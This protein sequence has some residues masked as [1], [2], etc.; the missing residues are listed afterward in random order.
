MSKANFTADR[1]IN[2]KCDDGKQQSIYWDAKTPGLGLRV[3][4]NGAK[5]YVFESRLHGKSLR[6]TIG[7]AK[8]WT[9]GKAQ[10][11]ASRLR[12]LIDQGIDPRQEKAAKQ[13]AAELARVEAKRQSVTLGEVWGVYVEERRAKWSQLSYRDHIDLSS[14]GGEA[15]KRG[16]GMTEPGPLASLLPRKMCSLTA[17]TIHEWMR[18]EAY[19][20]PTRTRLAFNLLRIFR[21]WCESKAEY[22]GLVGEG[23]LDPRMTRD[24]LPKRRP[25]TDVIQREQLPAWFTAVFKIGNPVMSAYLVGLLMTGAR[26]RS[27]PD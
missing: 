7:N 22:C 17:D 1:V 10:S 8:S 21:A 25:K 2:F 11:E 19:K 24:L 27:W 13:N 15:K 3:T 12:T 20:R 4:K 9:V 23:V 14:R 16:K 6:V 18:I 5:S 26:R